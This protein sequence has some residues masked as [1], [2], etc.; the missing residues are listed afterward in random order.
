MKMLFLKHD[1]DDVAINVAKV[2]HLQRM[3]SDGDPYTYVNFQGGTFVT[4]NG[5]VEDV[6]FQIRFG[7][8]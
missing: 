4:V 3:K 6:A 7:G 8:K 5:T 1:G 2:T